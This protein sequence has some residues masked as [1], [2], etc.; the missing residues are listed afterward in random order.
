MLRAT[1]LYMRWPGEVVDLEG[2]VG[3]VVVEKEKENVI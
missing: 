1:I 2:M 3:V